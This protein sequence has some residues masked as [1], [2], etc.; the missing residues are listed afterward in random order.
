MNVNRVLRE[1]RSS[2]PDQGYL[3]DTDDEFDPSD[4]DEGGAV[5]LADPCGSLADLSR[6]GHE[7]GH[8]SESDNDESTRGV[9]LAWDRA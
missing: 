5:D 1:L 2:N 3:D 4:F 9:A 6:A 7:G 8:E